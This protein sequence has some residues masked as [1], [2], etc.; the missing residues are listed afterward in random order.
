LGTSSLC[1]CVAFGHGQLDDE[2]AA[3]CQ[4]AV[5]G[6]DQGLLE[7]VVGIGNAQEVWDGQELLQG[8]GLRAWARWS[9]GRPA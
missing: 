5:V 6:G 2:G 8:C 1:F 9:F 7:G 4:I 3:I